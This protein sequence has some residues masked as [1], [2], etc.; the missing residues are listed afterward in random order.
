MTKTSQSFDGISDQFKQDKKEDF[1]PSEKDTCKN[2]GENMENDPDYH[3][4]AYC[5]RK[6][7]CGHEKE[8]HNIYKKPYKVEG[9]C[10]IPDKETGVFCPCKKFVLQDNGEKN[11]TN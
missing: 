2:C 10:V 1:V 9:C 6:C 7:K 8:E 4:S 5:K 11:E 3:N